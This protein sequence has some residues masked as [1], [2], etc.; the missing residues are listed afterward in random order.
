MTHDFDHQKTMLRRDSTENQ[1]T[2]T[3]QIIRLKPTTSD[4]GVPPSTQLRKAVFGGSLKYISGALCF[5]AAFAAA[6]MVWAEDRPPHPEIRLVR[7]GL[8]GEEAISALGTNLSQV[9]LHIRKT[10]GELRELFRRDK[11]AR[12]DDRGR[13]FYV[14]EGIVA[15]VVSGQTNLNDTTPSALLPLDQTFLLHSK[16]GSLKVIFLDF[17]GHTLSGNGW[18][19]SYNGGANIV[20]P[21]WDTDG[22]P[23]VF[24]NAERTAIQQIWLRVA[25]D[26]AAFDVDVTTEFPG[27]TA[28]NRIDSF[29][30]RYG[31]RAL[32]SPIGYVFG[33]PGGIAFIGSFDDIGSFNKPA[34][35]FPENLGNSEKN[36]AEA[37]SHEVGHNLGLSHDG[38]VGGTEYYTGQGNWAPIM[39]LGYNRPITQWSRG[40]Y[41]NAN[42]TQDDLVVITQNGLVNRT[43]DFGSTLA[44]AT[45][46]LGNN[47]TNTGIIGRNDV[48]FFSVQTGAGTAQITVTPWERGANLHLRVSLYN[49]AGTVIT[50]REEI[51]SFNGVRAVAFNAPVSAGDNFVSI[52]G[53]GSGNPFTTGYSAYASQGSYT[54]TLTLP[55]GVSAPATVALNF[56]PGLTVTGSVGLNYRVEYADALTPNT[57][58]TL[59]NFNPLPAS[60][61]FVLDPTP[62]TL[63]RRSY[64]SLLLLP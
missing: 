59:T 57:W 45:A 51:D 23:A 22:N 48:D 12:L 41:A 34:L 4:T 1:S 54:L 8:R 15:P 17:D 27:E 39:G 5:L 29:D 28:M 49:S 13:V 31:T 24:G 11:G 21:P 25:E 14:C 20:A 16:L 35:I 7:Q 46:L 47:I 44:T 60:P 61:I 64:R 26:Y 2:V 18:T 33:N 50:N 42:N 52:E 32:V 30:S 55:A 6:Q 36:I 37:I 10:P 53:I 58:V 9:A 43:D 56:Y 62:G 3:N 63:A 40:E 38:V 19:A